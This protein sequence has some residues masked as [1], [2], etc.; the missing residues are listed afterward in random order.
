[1]KEKTQKGNP[2][3]LAVNQHVF[4]AAS[5]RR[6]TNGNGVVELQDI[7]RN[8]NRPAAPGDAIFC[9]F[10][11]WDHGAELGF[12]PVE[13]RFQDLA[14]QI[15]ADESKVLHG[16]DHY[17]ISEFYALWVARARRR[18]GMDDVRPKGLAKPGRIHTKDEE[19]VLESNGY[20]FARGDVFPGRTLA[21]AWIYMQISHLMRNGLSM[22]RWGIQT[23]DEGEF[24]VPEMPSQLVVPVT[25]TLCLMPRQ[26]GHLKR[27]EVS[28]LN[29]ATLSNCGN[30]YFSRELKNCPIFE[31][32]PQAI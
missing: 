4:P 30:Y 3:Q 15:I 9:A 6:F 11:A 19:E 25:P 24:I 1:M 20:A 29:R 16:A 2:Y 12:R 10:R 32:F 7:P 26:S 13:D 21:G 14:V 5:I 28:A 22:T 17:V 23:S 8:R 31:A 18:D 27:R